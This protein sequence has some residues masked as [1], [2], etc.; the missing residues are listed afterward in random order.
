MSTLLTRLALHVVPFIVVVA[1]ESVAEVFILPL[2]EEDAGT[3]FCFFWL[4]GVSL[5]VVFI[6]V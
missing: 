1:E 4:I 2:I 5:F 6:H 3:G